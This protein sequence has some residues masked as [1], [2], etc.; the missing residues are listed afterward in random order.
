M[1]TVIALAMIPGTFFI[2]RYYVGPIDRTHLAAVVVALS[3]P[4]AAIMYWLQRTF[5][6]KVATAW[7][8]KQV[9]ER[10]IGIMVLI[11][12]Q[13]AVSWGKLSRGSHISGPSL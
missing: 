3:L 7:L 4:T 11:C 2:F 13:A 12:A 9:D 5:E 8:G 10:V 6:A 1:S